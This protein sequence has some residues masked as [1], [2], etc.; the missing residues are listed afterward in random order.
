MAIYYG[1]SRRLG[2]GT[3]AMLIAISWCGFVATSGLSADGKSFQ[4]NT[5]YAVVVFL[6]V[7][8]MNPKVKPGGVIAA[9]AVGSY[10]LYLL[11]IPVGVNILSRLTLTLGYSAALVCSLILLVGVCWVSYRY[12]ERPSQAAGRWMII[13]AGLWQRNRTEFLS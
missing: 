2:I 10:S 9:V 8:W 11:H 12:V 13:R 5:F 1:W 3:V 7:L 4:A 6:L